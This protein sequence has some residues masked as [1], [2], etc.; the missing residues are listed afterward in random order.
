MPILALA[1]A[2][3]LAALGRLIIGAGVAVLTFKL[4]DETVRPYFEDLFIA[5]IGTS[6]TL[7]S[8]GGA[9]SS[10]FGYFEITHALQIVIA[11]YVA[12]FSIR[13]ARVAFSA[14][15]VTKA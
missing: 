15:S 1:L 6:Q 5:I 12:A 3:M 13:I 11:A 14:F 4:L 2:P 9:G 10:I 7:G 8:V